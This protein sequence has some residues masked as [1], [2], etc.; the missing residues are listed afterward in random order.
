MIDFRSDN[1]LGCSPEILEA[2][3]KASHGSASAYGFDPITERLR[4]RVRAIFETDC[5]ILPVSTGTAANSLA[6]AAMT[7]TW[8]G[9]FAHNDSHVYREELG[10][11]EFFSNGAKMIP[12][13]GAD[14]KLHAT[15]VAAAI[16]DVERG[17]RM[18]KP[19][20]LSITQATESGTVYSPQELAELCEAAHW[21]HLGVQVDGARFANAVVSAGCSPA[22]LSWKAGVDVLALGAT[23]NGAMA[24]ELLVIFKRELHEE[25]AQR[26]HRSGHRY[27]KMRFL[28][29]QL[30]AYL[31]NDLWLRN[32]RH[33]NTAAEHLAA[34]FEEHGIETL[35]PV[36]ANVV[37]VRLSPQMAKRLTDGGILF[38]DWV[39]FGPDAYRFVTGFDTKEEDVYTLLRLLS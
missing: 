5:E 25:L 16:D 12:I 7:P 19:S 32:A 22:E 38:Y 31:T 4:E 17:K 2:L 8:G 33:A 28:S 21:R 1:T 27:S 20:C 37:F 10:A 13:D 23:K 34:G 35:R 26:L 14:G 24:A 6:I 18:A 9:I 11:P 36:E 30:D 3:S 29:A 15:D 39:L